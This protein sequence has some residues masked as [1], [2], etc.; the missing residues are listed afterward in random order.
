MDDA[1]VLL[2][3]ARFLITALLQKGDEFRINFE[4]LGTFF[5]HI[6]CFPHHFC[7][8]GMNFVANVS[9]PSVGP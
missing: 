1:P 3:A 6:C 9:N 2:C 5:R 7:E 8:L 4:G